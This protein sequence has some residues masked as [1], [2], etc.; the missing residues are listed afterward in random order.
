MITYYEENDS[1]RGAGD[2][3]L[4]AEDCVSRIIPITLCVLCAFTRASNNCWASRAQ[5]NLLARDDGQAVV[6]SSSN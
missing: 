2:A 6:P 5:L 3:E 1:R 4:K